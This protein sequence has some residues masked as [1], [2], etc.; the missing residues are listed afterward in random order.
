M[1]DFK[2][3]AARVIILFEHRINTF[4]FVCYCIRA[5]DTHR[6]ETFDQLAPVSRLNPTVIFGVR[7]SAAARS[8]AKAFLSDSY[9]SSRH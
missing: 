2:S 8:P 3:I 5:S 9:R 6:T 4:Y 1:P 7:Y